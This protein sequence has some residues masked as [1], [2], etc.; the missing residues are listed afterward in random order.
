MPPSV[1]RS[2]AGRPLPEERALAGEVEKGG[3]VS[4]ARLPG[5]WASMAALSDS[6]VR[7]ALYLAGCTSQTPQCVQPSTCLGVPLTL[8]SEHSPLSVSR[9]SCALGFLPCLLFPFPPPPFA[10]SPTM[11]SVSERSL[12]GC[13]AAAPLPLL[14]PPFSRHSCL[15]AYCL[16]QMQNALVKASTLARS[17]GRP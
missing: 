9:S 13:A 2:E 7:T 17:C 8:P 4:S 12:G 11:S 14:S 5:L 6:P 10:P 1:G 3:W 15:F 16:L